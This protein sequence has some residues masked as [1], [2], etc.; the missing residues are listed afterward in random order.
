MHSLAQALTLTLTLTLT[1][2]HLANKPQRKASILFGLILG[3][4]TDNSQSPSF[5][6]GAPEGIQGGKYE[7][8][9]KNRDYV[10]NTY[11]VHTNLLSLRPV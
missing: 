5:I 2:N 4:T 9:R 8:I 7:H 6:I 3:S 1:L 11:L 10:Q